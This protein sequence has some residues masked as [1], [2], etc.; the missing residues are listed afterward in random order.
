MGWRDAINGFTSGLRNQQPK[1]NEPKMISAIPGKGQIEVIDTTKSPT[2][3]NVPGSWSRTFLGPGQP[4][5]AI[6]GSN[7][8]DKDAETEPRAFQYVSSIN[9][10]ISPRI[11]Y[12]LMA[13]TDIRR[14]AESVPEVAMCIRLLTEE[15]KAFVP[16]IVDVKENAMLHSKYEWMTQRPD[17]FNPFPVWLSRFLYNVL[18][19]DAGCSYFAYNNHREVTSARVID[20]STI[21]VVIDESG[22]QPRP[23]APA[24]QQ[25]IWGVPHGYFNTRQLWYKPRHL[26]ADAP[27]GRS[28]IEDSLP[29]V[30]LLQSLWEYEYDK[31][32]VGNIP[33]MVF[34]CPENWK[35]NAD[36]ILEAEEAFNARMTGSS[37]ERVRARFLPFGMTA[38]QTK[39]LGFNKESYDA[40]TNAVRMSFGILQSEVGEGPENGL[41]GKGYAEAMQSAFYRMGLAPL[42]SYVEGHFNDI[43]RINGDSDSMS[44]KMEFP[45]ESLDPSKEEEK[46]ATRFQVGGIRRDEYRQGISM[47]ALGGD[48]GAFIVTPGQ[49]Q[50]EDDGT[51][52]GAGAGGK[53]GM[54]PV[55]NSNRVQVRHP[56]NVIKKPIRVLGNPVDVRKLEG[57]IDDVNSLKPEGTYTMQ[58]FHMGMKEEQEHLDTVD[59][60]QSK[61]KEIVL[62]HLTEDPE[63]YSKLKTVFD[64]FD[65]GTLRKSV[66][67]EPGDDLYFGAN[68]TDL[69]D[70][71]M[72]N[73]GA[74]GSHIIS[75]GGTQ[76]L[77]AQPAVWKP[78]SEEKETLQGW[79]GGHLYCRG[80]AAYILDREL[81]PD[82]KHYLI[83][84]TYTATID[85]DQGSVQHYVI[86][87]EAR[88]EV[89]SYGAEWV[90]Q[91]AVLDYIMGQVD[92]NRKN[93][94]T[95]PYDDKRPILIDSDLSFPVDPG[96]KLHSSFIDVMTG[97]P[98]SDRTLNQVQ[99]LVGNH[100]V[101]ADLQ[102]LLE[103]EDAVDNA[104]Q[105][106]IFLTQHGSIEMTQPILVKFDEVEDLQKGF[107][108]AKH[109]RKG[110]GAGGGEFTSG[111]GV[112]GDSK[113][114]TARSAALAAD[115][116]RIG[117]STYDRAK[118]VIRQRHVQDFQDK[119]W[120]DK[121]DQDFRDRVAQGEQNKAPDS[122]SVGYVTPDKNFTGPGNVPPI[123]V[124]APASAAER[125][126]KGAV[127]RGAGGQK[128]AKPKAENPERHH[129][130]LDTPEKQEA[131]NNLNRN[132]N[133]FTRTQCEGV[134]H[135]EMY[136]KICKSGS[137]FDRLHAL[138]HVQ[139]ELNAAQQAG[140][141]NGVGYDAQFVSDTN[142]NDL[143]KIKRIR[144]TN[145]NEHL[146]HTAIYHVSRKAFDGGIL[147]P[148]WKMG[149]NPQ[150]VGG[151]HGAEA[152]KLKAHPGMGINDLLRGKFAGP[153]AN[154]H[155]STLNRLKIIHEREAAG[156]TAGGHK[157]GEIAAA[158]NAA[159]RAQNKAKEGVSR[160]EA[161]RT[162]DRSEME[163]FHKCA[164]P[165]QAHAEEITNLLNNMKYA[166]IAERTSV[167]DFSQ[168][169]VVKVRRNGSHGINDSHW[170]TTKDGHEG[171]MKGYSEDYGIPENEVYAK[172][173]SVKLGA[174]TLVPA[175]AMRDTEAGRMSVMERS[176]GDVVASGQAFG[177]DFTTTASRDSL[178]NML[179]LTTLTGNQDRHDRNYRVNS[180]TGEFIAID[181]GFACNDAGYDGGDD[182]DIMGRSDRRSRS[183]LERA[184]RESVHK[185]NIPE[186]RLNSAQ[187]DK[188]EAYINSPDCVEDIKK[189]YTGKPFI[190]F[191]GDHKGMRYQNDADLTNEFARR[192]ILQLK[193]GLQVL[194]NNVNKDLSQ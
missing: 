51:G 185:Y 66:G 29:A 87:R 193:A 3:R 62:D 31:Y 118:D 54:I 109:P 6:G 71:D 172:Q 84:V 116:D 97:K 12:G 171:L 45:P 167:K 42:I 96:E 103:D 22:E 69:T 94:L 130:H 148:M 50:G 169:E 35:D 124:K 89:T 19:Y 139:G 113:S 68:V 5:D 24:F 157:P 147:L 170:I 61:I 150:T 123:K 133:L 10:T 16:T 18:V 107:D 44:F 128:L 80:E 101:W 41:G 11:G 93:W 106:A 121:N 46:Y 184:V 8:R 52:G 67:V 57:A 43:I 115:D 189:V 149:F 138:V 175:V 126:P 120:K 111:G 183:G 155:A 83:P 161:M 85:D 145:R 112:V 176:A 56:L 92:R 17:R 180:K 173:L 48:E 27:Y 81:A 168:G 58:E 105:R 2:Q 98:L 55:G 102:D 119:K 162:A 100:D 79:V 135:V 174:P 159:I 156:L 127:H 74:N 72:P 187:V 86:Q 73:Q 20:G 182:G 88:Q 140:L 143:L 15:M 178:S 63:Y 144:E 152:L 4:F 14:L 122:E 142:T 160:P 38:L 181:N 125:L 36:E 117:T 25:I 60:D 78:E 99:L 95:H 164:Q 59:G 32:Q 166:S 136:G 153:G 33:E 9:S 90:E 186:F 108:S 132:L 141:Q 134:T 34:S 37:E 39:D 47:P 82:E 188:A 190:E 28:P 30:K 75:I 192:T 163:M 194:K 177:V 91:A 165:A 110:K 26:R 70:V 129:V 13:F 53:P 7:A 154:E 179:I 40:A 65:R 23:P 137:D 146:G 21:F 76:D 158:A 191:A 77:P 1:V 49:G 104:K 131:V 114:A 151:T 64:K